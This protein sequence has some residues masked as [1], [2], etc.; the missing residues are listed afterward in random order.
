VSKKSQYKGQKSKSAQVSRQAQ[1]TQQNLSNHGMK[2]NHANGTVDVP[3]WQQP[4]PSRIYSADD[5]FAQ[6]NGQDLELI[7]Y[8]RNIFNNDPSTAVKVCISQAN[9]LRFAERNLGDFFLKL[10]AYVET[11]GD[12]KLVS[13]DRKKP[14]GEGNVKSVTERSSFDRIAFSEGEAEIDFFFVPPNRLHAQSLRQSSQNE[15]IVVPLLTV[16]LQ[17]QILYALLNEVRDIIPK[18]VTEKAGVE[19]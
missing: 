9:T 11:I 16:T 6:N 7:F 15:E 4:S 18:A 17:T 14:K 12:D 8:Q 10:R 5:A 2:F 1:G 3:I 13:M 19:A